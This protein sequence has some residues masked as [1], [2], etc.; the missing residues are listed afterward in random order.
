MK[1]TIDTIVEIKHT[2]FELFLLRVVRFVLLVSIKKRFCPL[3]L[4][5]FFNQFV[6]L[7]FKK[8]RY[9]QMKILG[10]AFLSRLNERSS[11]CH[12]LSQAALRFLINLISPDLLVISIFSV[13][14]HL[15]IRKTTHGSITAGKKRKKNSSNSITINPETRV[16]AIQG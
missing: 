14:S 1:I 12:N 8:I 3:R 13:L 15:L 7:L 11:S 10:L 9:L 4:L 2:M 6:R 16:E 5:L